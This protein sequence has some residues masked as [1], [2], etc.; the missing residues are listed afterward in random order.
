MQTKFTVDDGDP[1][2]VWIAFGTTD[3]P[4]SASAFATLLGPDAAFSFTVLACSDSTCN[5]GQSGQGWIDYRITAA[6]DYTLGL[7]VVQ[8]FG[9]PLYDNPPSYLFVDG[10]EGTV[11]EPVTLG[12]IGGGLALLSILRRRRA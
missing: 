10:V 8:P 1:V 2:D 4:S 5:S 12:L 6:G 7:G 11:P 9:P 3:F